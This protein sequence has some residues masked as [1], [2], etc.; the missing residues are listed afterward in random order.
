[1]RGERHIRKFVL[2]LSFIAFD[3]V[4]VAEPTWLGDG[5]ISDPYQID[6]PAELIYLGEHDGYYSDNFILTADIDLSGYPFDK[7]IIAPDGSPE[8]AGLFDGNYHKI[9]NIDIDAQMSNESYLG[10]FGETQTSAKIKNLGLENVVITGGADSN[11][12]GTMVGYCDC[13]ISNSYST[14]SITSGSGTYNIGGFLGACLGTTLNCYTD[15]DVSCGSGSQRLGGFVGISQG[16]YLN[17][18]AAGSVSGGTSYVKGFVGYVLLGIGFSGCY[19]LHPDNGGGP[20]DP[21][22]PALTDV[23]MQEQVNFVDWDFFGETSNGTDELW[24]MDVYPALSWQ[25]PVGLMNFS[26]LAGYWNQSGFTQDQP[27][28]RVDWHV[29][30]VV[31]ISDLSL[32]VG[33]WLEGAVEKHYPLALD[34]DFETGDFSKQPWLLGGSADWLIDTATVQ[35]GDY[36]AKSGVT[37]D[38]QSSYLELTVDT[39]G[40]DQITFYYKVSSEEDFD[41]FHFYIGDTWRIEHSGDSG[42]WVYSTFTVYD[43]LMTFRWSYDKDSSGPGGD[44]CAWIDNIVFT[45][46]E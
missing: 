23:Q 26:M 4:C 7:A 17:C 38:S 19:H 20:I 30:G 43:D 9:V 35:Q 40:Y 11:F 3:T 29:D 8:F 28:A 22:V 32:L 12:I 46:E 39:T 37:G 18:Y 41:F 5:T 34:D 27:Q 44:D 10:L 45:L 33:S 13:E 21:H 36:S 31:D 1:M 2:L 6:T 24:F 16:G 14:G 42:G 15:V 25:R